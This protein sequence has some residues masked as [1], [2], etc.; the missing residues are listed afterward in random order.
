M[1]Q[2]LF[3]KKEKQD[4]DVN[5]KLIIFLLLISYSYLKLKYLNSRNHSFFRMLD[6]LNILFLF[7]FKNRYEKNQR[8]DTWNMVSLLTS[9]SLNRMSGGNTK[10]TLNED[11]FF[12]CSG[13]LLL[14]YFIL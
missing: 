12:S 6:D 4:F 8:S 2:Q 1:I 9:F 10:R 5:L 3:R 14:N 11:F 7:I 13:V